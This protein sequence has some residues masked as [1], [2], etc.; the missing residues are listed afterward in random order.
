MVLSIFCLYVY[1]SYMEEI[2]E[3]LEL[4]WD[5]L[6]FKML[7]IGTSS[8]INLDNVIYDKRS[9]YTKFKN[10]KRYYSEYMELFKYLETENHTKSL[11]IGLKF[12]ETDI[13]SQ[14]IL[15]ERL[16]H[17]LFNY[18]LIYGDRLCLNNE[19]RCLLQTKI[20]ISSF[21]NICLVFEPDVDPKERK[22]ISNK[23]YTLNNRECVN[24][25][26]ARYYQRNKELLKEKRNLKK[27]YHCTN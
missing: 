7:W 12:L 13:P 25:K 17:Y 20:N 10:H 11:T 8:S 3:E 9:T 22:K 16:M 19:Y 5:L 1:D 14:E 21:K 24:A 18:R 15:N 6:R 27:R 26:S 2:P 4:K 23:K